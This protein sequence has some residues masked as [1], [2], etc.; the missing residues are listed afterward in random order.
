MTDAETEVP[1]LWS[2]G[3]KSQL[4]VKAPDAGKD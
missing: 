3:A 2:P 4:I 1:V